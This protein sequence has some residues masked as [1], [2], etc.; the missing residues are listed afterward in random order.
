MQKELSGDKLKWV[1][2]LDYRENFV[3]LTQ[4]EYEVYSAEIQKDTPKPFFGI[5]RTG[6]LISTRPIS[7]KLNPEWSDP[8]ETKAKE[9][10]YR[11]R[12]DYLERRT[13]GETITWEEYKK[14]KKTEIK[15]EYEDF[16]KE[17]ENDKK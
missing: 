10:F 13:R 1:V 11:L 2:Q 5:K 9:I 6:E 8:K 12:K 3:F 15:S 7:I 16:I 14:E 4:E 17:L